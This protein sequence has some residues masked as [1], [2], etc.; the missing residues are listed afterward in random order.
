MYCNAAATLETKSSCR[1]MVMGRLLDL[2]RVMD[3]G[4]PPINLEESP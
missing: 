1:M 4:A 3:A 2:Y